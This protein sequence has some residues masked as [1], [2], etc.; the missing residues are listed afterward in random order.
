[1]TYLYTHTTM[2]ITHPGITLASPYYNT[3][4][5]IIVAMAPFD[6]IMFVL[7]R[8]L[9]TLLSCRDLVATYLPLQTPFCHY[10]VYN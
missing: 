1:M 9:A 5:N 8:V 3:Y 10:C 2:D 4:N 6:Y 7:L